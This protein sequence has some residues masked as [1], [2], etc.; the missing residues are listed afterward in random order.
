MHDIEP[1]VMWFFAVNMGMI[2]T[3]V[4]TGLAAQPR[5]YAAH[6]D[7][8]G[9]MPASHRVERQEGLLIPITARPLNM[10]RVTNE[11]EATGPAQAA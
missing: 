7:P 5:R 6:Q 8:Y 11:R 9:H 2:L 1:V 3:M 4:M 10:P